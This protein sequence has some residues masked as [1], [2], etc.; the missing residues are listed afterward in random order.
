MEGLAKGGQILGG[1][2]VLAHV[3]VMFFE[4]L[5]LEVSYHFHQ[6]LIFFLLDDLSMEKS[7]EQSGRKNNLPN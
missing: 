4:V 3:T 1:G 7:I 6:H 5:V 2:G